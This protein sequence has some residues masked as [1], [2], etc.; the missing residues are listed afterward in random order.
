MEIVIEL[1]GALCRL[2]GA[3][4]CAL[5]LPASAT[6][7]DA[8][9]ALAARFPEIAPRLENTACAVADALVARSAQ[10]D[11]GTTL[12]LIPPVSGG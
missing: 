6:V 2:T 3:Q 1:Y 5:E 11:H 7:A 8:L 9:E 4:R 12:A 10:L